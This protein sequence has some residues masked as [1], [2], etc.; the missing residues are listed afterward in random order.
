MFG[1]GLQILSLGTQLGILVVISVP[2]ELPH[3]LPESP[4][5]SGYV[6]CLVK[7]KEGRTRVEFAKIRYFLDHMSLLLLLQGSVCCLLF[8]GVQCTRVES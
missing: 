3:S 1:S 8:P 5:L 2:C 7:W 4:G 6:F